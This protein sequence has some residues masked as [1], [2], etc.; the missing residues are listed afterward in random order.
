M[1]MVQINNGPF[2]PG[3]A[4]VPFYPPKIKDMAMFNKGSH[5]Y[6]FDDGITRVMTED[7]A[8]IWPKCRM[9]DQALGGP[10][11]PVMNLR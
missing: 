7:Q 2:L 10:R 11:Y 3:T 9:I 8:T 6:L 1:A 4:Y 5:T